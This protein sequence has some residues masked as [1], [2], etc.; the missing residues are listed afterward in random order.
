ML[1]PIKEYVWFFGEGDEVVFCVCVCLFKVEN[2]KAKIQK[3]VF[4]LNL[5]LLISL[6]FFIAEE[7]FLLQSDCKSFFCAGN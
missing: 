6:E 1:E 2:E 4:F 3:Y 7:S 5:Q